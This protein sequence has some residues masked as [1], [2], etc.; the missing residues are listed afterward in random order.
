MTGAI[1]RIHK[2]GRVKWK[3]AS[4]TELTSLPESLRKVKKK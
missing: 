4:G 3:T 1:D 2:D